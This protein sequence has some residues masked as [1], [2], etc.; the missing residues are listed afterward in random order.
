MESL[1]PAPAS[2]LPPAKGGRESSAVTDAEG[3]YTLKYLRDDMG[4]KIGEHTVRI[5][6][7][8]P[9]ADR[10]DSVPAKY[11]VNSE[12]RRTVVA[13]NNEFNFDLTTR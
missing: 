12:L 3:H 8:N 7:A 9:H 2:A 13:G 1:W 10:P 5:S 11:N 4:A 6:T